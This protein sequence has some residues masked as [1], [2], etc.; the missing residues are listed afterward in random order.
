MPKLVLDIITNDWPMPGPQT[1]GISRRAVPENGHKQK[2]QLAPDLH[3]ARIRKT[4]VPL[5]VMFQKPPGDAGFP[6]GGIEDAIEGT[7]VFKRC[8]ARDDSKKKA[9]VEALSR[10]GMGIVHPANLKALFPN[11]PHILI[12][13]PDHLGGKVLIEGAPDVRHVCTSGQAIPCIGLEPPQE[14]GVMLHSISD[15]LLSIGDP[16]RV[17]DDSLLIRKMDLKVHNTGQA[18]MHLKKVETPNGLAGRD[19]SSIQV[20]ADLIL[21]GVELHGGAVVA[22]VHILVDVL[23]GFDRGDGLNINM[24][25]VL[26]DKI[27]GVADDPAIVDLLAIDSIGEASVRASG[28]GIGIL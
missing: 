13:L 15:D 10:T 27:P 14:S 26:P 16:V 8:G 25:A 6:K 21:T 9:K 17:E 19:I 28:A 23:D 18:L 7:E 22:L 1:L 11:M 12:C 4:V 3:L 24:A 2:A 20:L 5:I